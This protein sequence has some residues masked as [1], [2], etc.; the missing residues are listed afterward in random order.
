M[1]DVNPIPAVAPVL[2]AES[3]S[4]AGFAPTEKEK[5]IFKQGLVQMLEQAIRVELST[6]PLYLYSMYSI[7]QDNGGPGTQ[8]RAQ[9]AVVVHQEML[10][11]ALA[12]NLLTAVDEGPILYDESVVPKYGPGCTI[13]YSKIPLIL[14]RCEKSN[15]E[16][17]IKIEAPYE[18]PPKLSAEDESADLA[19][20][21]RGEMKIQL[22]ELEQ[23]NSIG[24]FYRDLEKKIKQTGRYIRFRNYNKQ[25]SGVDF[26][27]AMMTR[28]KNQDTAYTALQTIIGQG[29]GAVGNEEAHYQMFLDLY[30]KRTDWT[31]WPVVE[32]PTNEMY[33]NH[34]L[35]LQLSLAFDAAYCY[36]LTTIEKTWQVEDPIVRR[37]L[38][39][40]NHAIMIDILN[41]IS[42]ILVQQ[43]LNDDKKENAAPTFSFYPT[44]AH[45]DTDLAAEE[46]LKAI[47]DHL[48][49]AMKYASGDLK[50]AL[51]VISLS[52]NRI[53]WPQN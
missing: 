3:G 44:H 15:L 48:T 45:G 34:P 10:H 38:I 16:C 53:P 51:M 5:I 25:F 35:I 39:G 47:K 33:K 17:F 46:L 30:R 24:E 26:F 8:A 4:D 43:E 7:K 37:K 50:E 42:N 2:G 52:V 19:P 18:A 1:T 28:V 9:I 13:L 12:G 41:P 29:E 21:G 11:L 6:I 40:N 31:C 36:L 32:S 20:R 22:G 27:D 23:Y 14:E 49:A